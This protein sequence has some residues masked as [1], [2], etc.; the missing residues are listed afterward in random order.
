MVESLGDNKVASRELQVR[1]LFYYYLP[2][3]KWEHNSLLNILQPKEK[4]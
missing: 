3:Y 4:I 2:T 1:R